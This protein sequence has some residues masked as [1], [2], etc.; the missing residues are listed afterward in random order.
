MA[1]N[2]QPSV[3]VIEDQKQMRSFLRT[4]LDHKEYRIFEASNGSEGLAQAA[5][6]NP[7]LILLDLGLPDIDGIEVTSRLREW[8]TTPI[9]VLSVEGREQSKVDA[10][11]AGADD[12][13]TKPFGAAEL[14]ARMRV[15]LRHA[16]RISAEDGE[17]EITIGDLHVDLEA[18]R[19]YVRGEETHLTPIEWKLLVTLVK[20]AGKV[21]THRQILKNV[22]GP[23][24]VDRSHYV[25][26]YMAHLR[27]KIEEDP[28]NPKYIIT[29][30]GVGYR[31]NEEVESVTD[32]RPAA[33]ADDK[34]SAAE[35]VPAD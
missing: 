33:A 19:V 35:E 8:T 4:L 16:A 1:S 34:A 15:A 14:L 30:T 11:D 6:R 27:R 9:I 29:E 24:Y 12:Y 31:L 25:R 7:D 2:H 23:E 13:M 10:L 17:A 18:R 5:E 32:A 21:V 3:L 20:N 22:W 28:A 26:V